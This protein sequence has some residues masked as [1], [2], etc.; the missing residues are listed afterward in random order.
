MIIQ[1]YT[2]VRD[3]LLGNNQTGLVQNFN[4][5][6][7]VVGG[8]NPT[9]EQA[10]IPGQRGIYYG[11]S[12]TQGTTEWPTA[13]V[14]QFATY[15]NQVTVTGTNAIKPSAT[16]SKSGSVVP[17]SPVYTVAA[18]VAALALFLAGRI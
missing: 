8:E 15:I 14:Q 3:F 6:I 2:F 10:A 5:T 1:A 4:G 9:L 17:G 7:S 13:T 12:I 18:L 16:A 11:S